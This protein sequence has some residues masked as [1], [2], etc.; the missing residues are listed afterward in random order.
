[1]YLFDSIR[2]NLNNDL[3]SLP[4]NTGINL[5]ANLKIKILFIIDELITFA[6]TEKH[7][8]EVANN[9]N[10][11]KFSVVIVV[12]KSSASVESVFKDSG[13]NLFRF[14]LEK[15]YGKQAFFTFLSLVRFIRTLK[16]DI[17]QTFH[18]MSDTFGLLAAKIA[19]VSRIIS[20]RRDMG[21]LKSTRQLILNR[22][23]NPFIHQFIAVCE[24][25]RNQI[26][27]QEKIPSRKIVTICNGIDFRKYNTDQPGATSFRNPSSIASPAFVIGTICMLRE[28]K[29]VFLLLKAMTQLKS[30]INNFKIIIVGEGEQR[31]AL[32][33]FAEKN[34]LSELTIFPGYVSDVSTYIE[35]LDVICM[36]PKTNEGFSN[37]ILEEMAMGKPVIATD[38]G[39]NKELVVHGETG[40]IIEPNNHEALAHYILELYRNPGLRKDMG[41]NGKKR[42]EMQFPL[43]LMI[44]KMEILYENNI[45]SKR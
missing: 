42:A 23:C 25:V 5:N 30:I 31:H 40:F 36:T 27:N 6:G 8:Y 21:H 17:V 29:D 24:N 39:G 11:N 15:I 19:G 32:E 7:L 33:Q 34:G 37:V 20:S 1:M 26:I 44:K 3:N 35:I 4:V 22:F 18:F 43:T 38:V 14:N 9:L 45:K 41:I 16:P 10:K 12:F 2:K 13:I 28:E